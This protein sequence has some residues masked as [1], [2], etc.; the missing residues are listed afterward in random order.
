MITD[1]F[2]KTKHSFSRASGSPHFYYFNFVY[3]VQEV[4]TSLLCAF[5]VILRF[6]FWDELLYLVQK[7]RQMIK[8]L[9][10]SKLHPLADCCLHAVVVRCK[11]CPCQFQ[12]TYI[13]YH[14]HKCAKNVFGGGVGKTHVLFFKV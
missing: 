5:E 11:C 6:E 7:F 13:L 8:I 10:K 12:I 1:L 14:F 2:Q 4:N 3:F 9:D